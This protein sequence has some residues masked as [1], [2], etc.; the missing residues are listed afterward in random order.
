MYRHLV[1]MNKIEIKISLPWLISVVKNLKKVSH[2]IREFE[3]YLNNQRDWNEAMSLGENRK[4]IDS[5]EQNLSNIIN[6]SV[7]LEVK[8]KPGAE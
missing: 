5:L 6:N 1:E 3:G 2:N 4:Y 7:E 8:L